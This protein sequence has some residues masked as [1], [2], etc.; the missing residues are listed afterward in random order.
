M[1]TNNSE[2]VPKKKVA[3]IDD[4]QEMVKL[5]SDFLAPI[6]P[7]WEIR[8]AGSIFDFANT[9]LDF[10]PDVI[11]LD[12][13]LPGVKGFDIC[14]FIKTNPSF[15]KSKVLA[16]S[17]FDSKDRREKMKECGADDF[18]AKPIDLEEFLEKIKKLLAI[19]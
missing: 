8:S 16:V 6:Y 10:I 12:I 9:I 15:V 4:D 3:I 17:A 19:T 1:D 18:V 7:T 5:I 11:V 2:N 14:K 13:N